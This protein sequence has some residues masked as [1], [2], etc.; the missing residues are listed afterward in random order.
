MQEKNK[1]TNGALWCLCDPRKKKVLF[2]FFVK[3]ICLILVNFQ[4]DLLGFSDPFPI[5]AP[6]KQKKVR[7]RLFHI[8]ASWNT[9]QHHEHEAL[10]KW[11]QRGI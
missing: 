1:Q 8:V 3:L 9:Y 10:R 2:F 6:S 11:K 5:S 4:V 7:L